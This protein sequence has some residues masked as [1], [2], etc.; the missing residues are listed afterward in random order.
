VTRDDFLALLSRTTDDAWLTG[1]Q[2]DPSS[3]AAFYSLI[4]GFVRLSQATE[5][6]CLL[7]SI[8][9]APGGSRGR[10]TVTLTRPAPGGAGTLSPPFTWVDARGVSYGLVL[11]VTIGAG[12]LTAQIELE[13]FRQIE[14]VNSVEDMQVFPVFSPFPAQLLLALEFTAIA[15]PVSGATSDYLAANGNERSIFRQEGE[16]TENY[17]AR[18]R[19]IPD[20]VS[21]RAIVEA[22][23]TAVQ[24]ASLPSTTVYEPFDWSPNLEIVSA[25]FASPIVVTT[26]VEH[27]YEDGDLVRVRDVTVNLAANG[28]WRVTVLSPTSFEL[29]NSIGSGIGVGGRVTGLFP[30]LDVLNELYSG[31]YAADD[32]FLDD[33]FS[34][35]VS[36][37]EAC[38]YLLI[39]TDSAP[40]EPDSSIPYFDSGFLDD[41][42]YGFPD[43]PFHPVL[44]AGLLS[45]AEEMNRKRAACVQFDIELAGIVYNVGT[46]STAAAIPTVVFTLAPPA[47]KVWHYVDGFAGHTPDP[48]GAEH[49]V[50]ITYED[51]S[52]VTT[53][54]YADPDSEQITREDLALLGPLKRV[55][56]IEGLLTSNGVDTV[57]MSGAFRVVEATI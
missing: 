6:D 23:Q 1:I 52:V 9:E 43:V 24:T 4:D 21:P 16:T 22:V 20:A 51:A 27:G 29:D 13:T 55:A 5:Y 54:A 57:I 28:D 35:L 36:R 3:R 47:G 15:G 49:Q 18:I 41:S 2:E 8:S 50:R 38:A 7:G 56:M 46:G 34:L 31:I 48:T 42:V 11:P 14:A 17:R 39:Q 45:I 10:T 40:R 53:A 26:A 25:T 12:D 30:G 19:N 32:G 33:P 37:R 44:L